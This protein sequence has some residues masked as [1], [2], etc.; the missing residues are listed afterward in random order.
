MLVPRVDFNGHLR[1]CLEKKLSILHL[2]FKNQFQQF[3]TNQMDSV[4][5]A[6]VERGLHK[7]V[8]DSKAEGADIRLSNDTNPLNEVQSTIAYN[9]FANDKQHAEQ[10][11][12][13]NERKV[14]QDAEQCLE[15]RPLIASVIE[16]KTA[17]FLNQT[18]ESENDCLKKTIT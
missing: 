16:N 13:I 9:V 15:K 18:L 12:F 11:K 6:I 5:K 10:P 7:K 2:V 17:E 3:I 1:Y 14:N 8:H 4:E